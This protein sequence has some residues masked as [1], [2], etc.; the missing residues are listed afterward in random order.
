MQKWLKTDLQ[1]EQRLLKIVDL[2]SRRDRLLQSIELD[3]EALAQLVA[4]YESAD[5][6]CAAAALRRRL[7]WYRKGGI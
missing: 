3:L 1:A 4:D 2:G 7:E 6:S 5:L